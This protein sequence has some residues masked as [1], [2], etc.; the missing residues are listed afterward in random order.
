MI[1]VGYEPRPGPEGWPDCGKE[2]H[3]ASRIMLS[4]PIVRKCLPNRSIDMLVGIAP[5]KRLVVITT[6]EDEHVPVTDVTRRALIAYAVA[7]RNALSPGHRYFQEEARFYRQDGP[8]TIR[9]LNLSH[10]RAEAIALVT[11]TVGFF[12][13]IG[14]PNIARALL[15]QAKETWA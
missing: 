7:M 4:D 3:H 8:A 10:R 14:R 1:A 11:E 12:Q 2:G 5:I 9:A 15:K 6:I 13:R